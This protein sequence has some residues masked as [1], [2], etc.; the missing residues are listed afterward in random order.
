MPWHR[1]QIQRNS[2]RYER[3]QIDVYDYIC[4]TVHIQ[5][6]SKNILLNLDMYMYIISMISY[7]CYM[8]KTYYQSNVYMQVCNERTYIENVMYDVVTFYVCS[9]RPPTCSILPSRLPQ[10]TE[11][12]S[13]ILWKCER[14]SVPKGYLF[15]LFAL[16]CSW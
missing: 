12:I 8:Q 3:R 13:V 15:R 1:V 6:I 7:R 10:C 11:Q 16:S 9:R 14:L 2:P 5:R 4:K